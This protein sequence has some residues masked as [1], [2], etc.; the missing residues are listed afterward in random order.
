MGSGL[1]ST[2]GDST[3]LLRLM[4]GMLGGGRKQGSGRGLGRG[5]DH[6]K[7]LP[8]SGVF[9]IPRTY[10]APYPRASLYRSIS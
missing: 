2:E 7:V 6:S 9:P 10:C 8:E 4:H 5:A 1:K 3:D